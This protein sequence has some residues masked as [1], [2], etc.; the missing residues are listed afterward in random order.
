MM[1]LRRGLS[2]CELM[3]LTFSVMFWMVRFFKTGAE[4]AAE[5]LEEA[6]LWSCESKGE[7]D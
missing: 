7:M 2:H 4:W 1:Y 6:M 3:R 5:P